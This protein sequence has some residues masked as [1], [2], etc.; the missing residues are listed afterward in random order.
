MFVKNR[1]YPTL[2][3]TFPVCVMVRIVLFGLRQ[4]AALYFARST[5]S[6][7]DGYAFSADRTNCLAAIPLVPESSMKYPGQ[8]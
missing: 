5:S 7:G 3:Q 2:A 4:F 6:H 1:S 8:C